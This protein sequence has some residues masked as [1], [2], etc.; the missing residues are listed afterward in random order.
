MSNMD[1][2]VIRER[3]AIKEINIQPYEEYTEE[4]FLDLIAEFKTENPNSEVLISFTERTRDYYGEL[5]D[6]ATIRL[7]SYINREETDDEY[8]KRRQKEEQIKRELEREL[9]AKEIKRQK[10]EKEREKKKIK[11]EQEEKELF[12]KLKEKYEK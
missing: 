12:L 11:E 8:A 5:D 3:S 1:K 10:L 6:D 9:V 4:F 2:K 7:S